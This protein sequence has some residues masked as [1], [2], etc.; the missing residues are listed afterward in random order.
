MRQIHLH[1]HQHQVAASPPPD[2]TTN[3]RRLNLVLNAP[4]LIIVVFLK[5]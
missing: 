4:H 5:F 2:V 1:R 3:K